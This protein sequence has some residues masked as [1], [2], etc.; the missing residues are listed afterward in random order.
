MGKRLTNRQTFCQTNLQDVPNQSGIYV[1][2]NRRGVCQYVGSAESGRLA[3][4]LNEHLA[5]RD[6]PGAHTFQIR[7]A[8][9]EDEARRLERQYKRRYKPRYGA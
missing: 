4:R 6:I 7:T 1:I 5:K 3:E 9:S 8:T 2:R